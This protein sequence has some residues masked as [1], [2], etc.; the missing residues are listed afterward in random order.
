MRQLKGEEAKMSGFFMID[1]ISNKSSP[2]LES[3]FNLAFKN[4]IEHWIW[5]KLKVFLKVSKLSSK[6]SKYIFKLPKNEVKAS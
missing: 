6:S 4:D 1:D 2:D 3:W 5:L